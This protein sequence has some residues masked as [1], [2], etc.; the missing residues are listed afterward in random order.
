LQVSTD[1][2]HP[3]SDLR[4]ISNPIP[5]FFLL[6]LYKKDMTLVRIASGFSTENIILIFETGTSVFIAIKRRQTTYKYKPLT[7][8]FMKKS[9]LIIFMVLVLLRTEAQDYLISFAGAGDTSV[10]SNVKVDNLTTGATVTLNEGDILH[11]TSTVGIGTLK[12]GNGHLQIYPNPMAEHSMLTFVAPQEG[13]AIICIVDLSGKTVYQYITRLSPGIHSFRV[14]GINQGMYLLKVIGENYNYSTK[15]ISQYSPQSEARI[16]YFSSVKS[17]IGNH[18]KSAATTIDM[19]Y[20]DGN[21][22]MYKGTSGQ[23]SAVVTDVPTGSKKTTFPFFACT[24]SDG[25]HYT[26]VQISSGKFSQT[27]MAENLKVGTGIDGTM[28]PT[29]NGI[30]EYYCYSDSVNLCGIYGGLYRWDEMMKYTEIEGSQGICPDGWHIPTHLEFY[31]L[32]NFLGGLS[33]AGGK[34]KEAGTTHWNANNVGATNETGFTALP[35]GE[36]EAWGGSYTRL[37]ITSFFWSSSPG[38]LGGYSWYL[39]VNNFE[40]RTYRS[41]D[42]REQAYSCR[43]IHD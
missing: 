5:A 23:Y 9:V 13:T 22:L 33:I 39:A 43:C 18:Q 37:G 42:Q 26:T 11:L 28:I 31:D 35:G 34:L 38:T 2:F 30:I 6:Y 19:P 7:I 16:E 17:T 21:I 1:I 29:D 36:R 8:S 32:E 3:I 4:E 14:S 25:N 24:D 20:A 10:V 27:W 40:A 12:P 41:D 15:L